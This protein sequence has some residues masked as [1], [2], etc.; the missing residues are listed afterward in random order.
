MNLSQ[1]RDVSAWKKR[2]ADGAAKRWAAEREKQF[3][4][5]RSGDINHND[6]KRLMRLYKID[7]DGGVYSGTLDEWLESYQ[8]KLPEAPGSRR[9]KA[10][11]GGIEHKPVEMEHMRACAQNAGPEVLWCLL[12]AARELDPAPCAKWKKVAMFA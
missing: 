7:V 9:P 12:V 2:L 8:I 10:A 5:I 3:A 1:V 6:R 11:D 4:R